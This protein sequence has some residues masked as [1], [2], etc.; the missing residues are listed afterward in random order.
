M[1]NII[2]LKLITILLLFVMSAN[3]YAVAVLQYPVKRVSKLSCKRQDFDTMGENCKQ[4]LPILK[5]K[6]YN[7]YKNNSTY[8]NYYSVLWGA[9]YRNGWDYTKGSHLWVDI[10]SA[11]NTPIYAIY[12]WKVVVAGYK[13]GRGNVVS[14][15]H[16]LNWKTF[17]SNYAHQ[18][19]ILVK[20]GQKVKTWQQIWKMWSTWAS[21]WNHLHFQI[22]ITNKTR[23]PYRYAECSWLR[24]VVNK[25][26]CRD[27]LLSNT[28]DPLKFIETN[29]K[30]LNNYDVV[31]KQLI[32]EQKIQKK[33]VKIIPKK[34]VKKAE[35]NSISKVNSKNN[36]TKKIIQKNT[37]KIYPK[38]ITWYFT[39]IYFY[40]T[41]NYF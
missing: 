16:K 32:K 37:K 23:H 27:G 40:C 33:V 39:Q 24:S 29:W 3:V 38:H 2:V 13:Y 21:T 30:I 31:K 14:I 10:A 19:K 28:I 41:V 7:K 9:T 1:R 8:R 11:K 22:D 25:G 4:D 20:V 26:L 35:N 15:E 18:T 17:Y 34:Q 6:D 36:I 12:D 5:S